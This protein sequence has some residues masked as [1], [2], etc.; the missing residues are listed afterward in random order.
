MKI[1]D[2]RAKRSQIVQLTEKY[3]VANVRIF[4]SV[5]R[6]ESTA[7][8][9]LDLLIDVVDLSRFSWGGGGLVADLENLLGCE[10][11]LVTTKG[12]HW[13]IRDKILDE[14]VPL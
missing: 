2:I 8:S 4:G 11:D 5:A 6:G 13:Y 7:D 12:L 3:G 14:A 10:V 1:H 9:D